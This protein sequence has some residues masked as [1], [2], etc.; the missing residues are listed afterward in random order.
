VLKT[1][2][3]EDAS[4]NW[5]SKFIPGQASP[6]ANCQPGAMSV[7]EAGTEITEVPS[8]QVNSCSAN[9]DKISGGIGGVQPDSEATKTP[10]M[11]TAA[12]FPNILN[13]L[14]C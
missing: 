1:K 5:T 14:F 9:A 6:A 7:V 13:S 12:S 11:A 8:T 10:V 3:A 4:S 2:S